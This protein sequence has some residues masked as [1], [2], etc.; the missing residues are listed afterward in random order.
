MIAEAQKAETRG[1]NL[2]P[3]PDLKPLPSVEA[4]PRP[5]SPSGAAAL[6]EDDVAEATKDIRSPV[7]DTQLS[8][9]FAAVRGSA[10]HRMLQVLPEIAFEKRE[11]AARRFLKLAAADWSDDEREKAWQSVNAVLNDAVYAPIFAKGSRAEVSLAG[12]LIIQG[13]QRFVSGVIDR[14]AVSGDVVQIVDF[15]TN[16][17]APLSLEQV[18]AAHILQLALYAELLKPIY[19]GKTVSAALLF[20]EA[21]RLMPLPPETLAAALAQLTKG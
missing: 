18:P 16:R 11:A 14:L 20:T 17:P 4:L 8:V 1:P 19:P 9:S 2:G 5:L 6:I 3:L 7:L 10:I 15:K 13:K 21:P 12:T